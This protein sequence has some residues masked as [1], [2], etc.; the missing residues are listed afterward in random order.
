MIRRIFLI[1][2]DSLGVGAA[3]DAAKYGFILKEVDVRN[4]K[5][6]I[7]PEYTG[8]LSFSIGDE[9][10]MYV[11]DTQI[12]NAVKGQ[13]LE[14]NYPSITS[15]AGMQLYFHLSFTG[16]NGYKFTDYPALILLTLN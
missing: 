7:I 11:F 14:I 8:T 10:K 3:P 2:L 4:N 9:S 16:S 5:V 15:V 12:V 1:V 6:I 13:A